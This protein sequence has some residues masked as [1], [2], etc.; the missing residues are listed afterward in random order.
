[1][2]SVTDLRKVRLLLDRHAD[3]NAVSKLGRTALFLAAMSDGSAGIVKLLIARGG[4]VKAIDGAKMTMLHAATSGND[5]ET[6]R[7]FVDARLD[8]NAADFAGF[9]PLMN[10]AGHGNLTAVK[11]LLAKGANVNAVSGDGSFQKVKAGTIALGHFTPLLLAA[12]F[13][14][15]DV[16]NALLAAGAA[17]NV[18]DIRGMTPLM[19]AVATDRQNPDIVRALVAKRADI[20]VKS[21]EGE[22]ALDWAHKIGRRAGIDILERAGA[23][24]TA[25]KP[26]AVPA[27]APATLKPSIERSVTLLEKTSAGF[28]S[29]GGC[30]SCH[31]QNITDLATSVARLQGVTVDAKA[32][33]LRQRVTTIP[34]AA[35][36]ML[37]ERMDSPGTPDVPLYALGALADTGYAPDRLT[38]VAVANLAANQLSDGRWQIGGIARPPIEDGDIFR[39]AL[40]IRALKVYGPPGRARDLNERVRRSISWL[41]AAKP[42]TTADRTMQLL[43]LH[44]AGAEQAVRQRVAKDILATQRPDGGWGQTPDLASDAYATGQALYALATG[45]GLSPADAAYRK[46]AQYLLATQRADGSWYV[47]SRAPKFQPY[48][49]SGFPYGSDQWISSMATGWA[50]TALAL[51]LERPAAGQAR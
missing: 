1:M 18:Q 14:P 49:E 32:M 11:M 5:T 34:F 39:V 19:L 29:N 36:P 47:R 37:L 30:A 21:L 24:A 45:G 50:T 44:W 26:I 42:T 2:W 28:L 31:A 3:V 6:I 9:T 46:G 8:V 12:T 4:N 23:V 33:S 40:G 20:N 38:D 43:G 22:T 48:F 7:M 25:P 17:V 41:A 16:V 35:G 51:A 15:P 10:A 13:G 27:S